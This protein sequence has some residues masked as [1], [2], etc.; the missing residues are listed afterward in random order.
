MV[1]KRNVE[2]IG[3]FFI[4]KRKSLFFVLLTFYRNVNNQWGWIVRAKPMCSLIKSQYRYTLNTDLQCTANRNAHLDGIVSV[5]R[6][7]DPE[8]ASR[9]RGGTAI[10]SSCSKLRLILFYRFRSTARSSKSDKGNSEGGGG[11]A[12]TN[13]ETEVVI[14]TPCAVFARAHPP[15]SRICT[16]KYFPNAEAESPKCFSPLT[17]VWANAIPRHAVRNTNTYAKPFS[18]VVA[19][20]FK[21]D[22]YR[23]CLRSAYHA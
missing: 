9:E 1:V 6:N 14:G 16:C 23:F 3:F 2:T 11:V 21:L 17:R 18:F 7:C 22:D 4:C 8:T 13:R 5:N 15:S 12:A 19:Q 10:E 20:R